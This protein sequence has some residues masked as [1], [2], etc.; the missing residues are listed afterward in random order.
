M[1]R[2]VAIVDAPGAAHLLAYPELHE[3]ARRC[4]GRHVV[5]QLPSSIV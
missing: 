4:T 5:D 3:R 1:G 2:A